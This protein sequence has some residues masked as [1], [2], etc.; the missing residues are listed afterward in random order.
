MSR[1]GR[2]IRPFVEA[3]LEAAARAADAGQAFAHLERAHVLAQDSTL[4]HLR[5]HWRMLRW[6]L[7][8]RRLREVA[9]QVGRL[10]GAA[11]KTAIGLVPRG[12]TGG[13]NVSAWRA[14]PIPAELQ[15]RIDHA[16]GRFDR[17]ASSSKP[18][19]RCSGEADSASGPTT[20][21]RVNRGQSPMTVPVRSQR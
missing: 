3:E 1:F 15:R 11:S 2:R 7:R 4:Q 21:M 9:G 20:H 8:H 13:S 6:G 5:V 12:N 19:Q 14:M 16:Q 10:L 18:P 17:R